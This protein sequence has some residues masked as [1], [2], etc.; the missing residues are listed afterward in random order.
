MATEI[1]NL[2]RTSR[3]F[4]RLVNTLRSW[5]NQARPASLADNAKRNRQLEG[6]KVL[7]WRER[8][9]FEAG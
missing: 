9:S 3:V 4:G 7:E 5:I 2:D 8:V 6:D 1:L